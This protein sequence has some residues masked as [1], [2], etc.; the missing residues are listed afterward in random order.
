[1]LDFDFPNERTDDPALFSDAYHFNGVFAKRMVQEIVARWNP[2]D[3]KLQARI[4]KRRKGLRCPP[5]GAADR[6]GEA[7]L[8]WEADGR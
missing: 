7:C 3:P 6:L 4:E 5:L 2:D 1:M 8:V